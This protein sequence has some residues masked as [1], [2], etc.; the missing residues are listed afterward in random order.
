MSTLLESNNVS[1]AEI[2]TIVN[3]GIH[4]VDGWYPFPVTIVELSADGNSPIWNEAFH[5]IL[6]D[7]AIAKLMER[8]EYFDVADAAMAKAIT[9]VRQM[10]KF[11]TGGRT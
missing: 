7:Y 3:A 6:V 1:D 8:E 9:G 5:W 11:Y 4:W 10:V 2:L